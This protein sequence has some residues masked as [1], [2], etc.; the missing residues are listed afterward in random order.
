MTLAQEKLHQAIGALHL[1]N[2]LQQEALSLMDEAD[3]EGTD[4][5]YEIHNGIE[6]LIDQ[7]EDLAEA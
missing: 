4:L 3:T 6:E 5:C 2:K 7:L 1:A